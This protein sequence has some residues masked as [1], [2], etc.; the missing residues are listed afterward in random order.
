MMWNWRIS[1]NASIQ[2]PARIKPEVRPHDQNTEAFSLTFDSD[3]HKIYYDD[4]SYNMGHGHAYEHLGIDPAQ[5]A[6]VIVR[7]DQCKR[8]PGLK[9]VLH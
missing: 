9:D 4:G 8:I 6:I 5:G 1:P 2:S 3:L 7:P